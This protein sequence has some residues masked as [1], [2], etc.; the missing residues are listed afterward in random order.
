MGLWRVFRRHSGNAPWHGR[1]LSQGRLRDWLELLGLEPL[2]TDGFFF[3]PPVR[4]ARVLDRLGLL[5][6]LGPRLW[7]PLN[8]AFLMS[9][10]KRVA[11]A[12]P[13]P[14]RFSYRPR[15]V[16]VSLA[17]PPARMTDGK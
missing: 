14:A 6:R 17:G 13:I 9:A 8:G 11:R 2:S 5:E 1:F 12:T 3:L 15:L 16:G 7:P 4:N 10:R